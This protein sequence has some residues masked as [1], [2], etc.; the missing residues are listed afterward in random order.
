MSEIRKILI[1]DGIGGVPLGRE[2]YETLGELSVPA[3]HFDCLQA[4]RRPFHGARS[5]Y[6]KLR[7]RGTDGDAFYFLPKLVE[8][9]LRD[10]ITREQPSH[11][12]VIGFIYKFFDPQL[13]R[14]FADEAGAG[15]FLYDTDTC[16]LYGRR[17]EF[18]F[19]V[20]NELPVYDRILS[21]S[22]VTTRFFRDTRWLEAMF[23]PFGAKPIDAPRSEQQTD[24]LFVGSGDLRRIFL[25]E[26]I[27]D[28]VT[29]R[30]NRWQRNFPLISTA[31]R[32][33]IDDCPVWGEELHALLSQ[34]KIVLNITRTD[35]YG[36]ETGINLRIFEA[37]AAG[38][39]LLTDHCDE[40]GELFRIGEEIETYRSS[41]ELAEKVRHY[42]AHPEARQAIAVAGHTAFLTHH[43]WKARLTH[44]LL[45]ALSD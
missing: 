15:L 23:V 35:F 13:L 26:G 41:G 33:R 17:R 32:A 9:E 27:R 36:A 1:L 20:E 39:F 37:L 18:I 7:N 42:L 6:A 34:S 5:A 4:R 24:V 28:H 44:Q 16:N 19:F 30:G 21:C 45:P 25:L 14:R 31:L 11:I 12:L 29:V 8:N 2:V 43:S 40:L 3:T 22:A 38:C 10:L